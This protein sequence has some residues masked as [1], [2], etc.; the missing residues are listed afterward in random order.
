[1]HYNQAPLALLTGSS[2]DH[3]RHQHPLLRYPENAARLLMSSN[4]LRLR[5][6]HDRLAA[7]APRPPV[8]RLSNRILERPGGDRHATVIS[9]ERRCDNAAHSGFARRFGDEDMTEPRMPVDKDR[10]ELI[11]EVVQR[12]AVY[13]V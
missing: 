5:P 11:P 10:G 1:M 12:D 3:D 4:E 6:R 7:L 2:T 8:D 9:A 13:L